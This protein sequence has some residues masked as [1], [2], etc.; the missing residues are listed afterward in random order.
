MLVSSRPHI[1]KQLNIER[2]IASIWQ[3]IKFISDVV[4]AIIGLFVIYQVL[5]M[6][7]VAIGA[8]F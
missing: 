4:F 1:N 3:A 6:L 7:F 5:I 2:K 8:G